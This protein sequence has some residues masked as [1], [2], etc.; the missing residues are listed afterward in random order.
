MTKHDSDSD[1]ETTEEIEVDDPMV[2]AAL[3]AKSPRRATAATST[4]TTTTTTA[5]AQPIDEDRARRDSLLEFGFVESEDDD[6][7]Q[8]KPKQKSLAA[9][10]AARLMSQSSGC[11]VARKLLFR[12][13]AKNI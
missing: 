13:A 5:P 6:Q 9:G 10:V 12:F 2:V 1:K 8:A 3:L 7:P 4:S 11:V